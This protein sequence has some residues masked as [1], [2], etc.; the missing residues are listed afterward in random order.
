MQLTSAMWPYKTKAE[1][2]RYICLV[3][4]LD[5]YTISLAMVAALQGTTIQAMLLQH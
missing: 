3:Q 2:S 1:L 4:K 5:S